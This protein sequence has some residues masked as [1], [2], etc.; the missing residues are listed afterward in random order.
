MNSMHKEHLTLQHQQRHLSFS[1]GWPSFAKSCGEFE[2]QGKGSSTYA[3]SIL[4]QQWWQDYIIDVSLFFSHYLQGEGQKWGQQLATSTQGFLGFQAQHFV[5]GLQ[6]LENCQYGQ[7]LVLSKFSANSGAMAA[8]SHMQQ[9]Q[10]L[11][12]QHCLTAK[13]ISTWGNLGPM[14]QVETQM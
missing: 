10:T 2:A 11:Q 4:E 8:T 5:S 14:L 13:L 12:D 9:Q 7:W 6:E 3:T 1:K